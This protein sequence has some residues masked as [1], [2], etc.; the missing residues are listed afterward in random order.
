VQEYSDYT[1]LKSRLK[2]DRKMQAEV[3]NLCYS[4]VYASCLRILNDAHYAEDFMHEAFIQAF[5]SIDSF[6]GNSQLSTWICRIA[7][8]KCL[9]HL[10]KRKVDIVYSDSWDQ[11]IENDFSK[12]IENYDVEHI[13]EAI[14]Q[15]PEG[16][17][18]VFNLHVLEGMDH[19][20]IAGKLG[21]KAGSSRAQYAR[22]R[23]KIRQLINA[24]TNG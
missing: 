5:K 14:L 2:T 22:A 20:I 21:I 15:L 11:N 19:E 10:K 1:F 4:K 12:P 18:I 8:N 9:D 6:K 24:K 7:I 17:R 23:T 3:Y 16:C 13:Q